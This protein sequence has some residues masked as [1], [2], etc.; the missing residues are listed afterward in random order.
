MEG[1]NHEKEKRLYGPFSPLVT[2][3]IKN[4]FEEVYLLT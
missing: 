2:G 4:N 3:K 1:F